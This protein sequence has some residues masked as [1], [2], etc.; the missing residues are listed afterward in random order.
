[1]TPIQQHPAKAAAAVVVLLGLVLAAFIVLPNDEAPAQEQHAEHADGQH[2]EEV[3]EHVDDEHT[4]EKHP[5]EGEHAGES[6]AEAISFTSAQVERFGIA[7]STLEAG[8]ATSTLARPATVLFDPDRTAA[9]GPRV[10]AKVVRVLKDLGDEVRRGEALAI[11]SSVELGQAKSA[12]R[13][14]LAH[15]ET[16]R[17]HYERDRQL[18]EREITSEAELLE[19]RATYH[20]AESDAEA[21]AETL[22]L[23]G[24]TDP[25]IDALT[26]GSTERPLSE[27][28]LVSPMSGTVQKRDLRPGQTISP[29]ETPV[30]VASTDELW[31]MI[32]A[33]ERDVPYLEE[34]LPVELEVRSQPGKTFAGTTDW[35]SY[36]LDPDT[37][38]V[39]VRAR[40][41]NVEG[42]LRAGMFGTAH[43]QTASEV[44]YALVPEEAVQQIGE[45]QVVFV[46]GDHEGEYRPVEVQTGEAAGGRVE[47]RAGLAPGDV[48]VTQGA[49]DLKSALTARTRS[50]AHHH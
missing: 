33:Y 20:E 50:A 37:R 44:T 43:I 28:A 21:A 29:S 9:V 39:R 17:A 25:Q 11:M 35:V 34:G 5:T 41:D 24:L 13:S 36:E 46:P 14:A 22:R 30:H 38:T 6:H 27:F 26:D 42:Q 31:V 12:Y 4:D 15:L 18:F 49:F 1:M 19:S 2:S 23:Y 10:E 45:R 16:A 8:S 48:A 47:L 32:D 40:V 7:T 3:I